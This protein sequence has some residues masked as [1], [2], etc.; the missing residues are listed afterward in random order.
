MSA[1]PN[2][3]DR[4]NVSQI[5]FGVGVL[6]G[7]LSRPDFNLRELQQVEDAIEHIRSAARAIERLQKRR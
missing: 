2:Q 5:D 4:I 6:R 3:I 7:V 1:R